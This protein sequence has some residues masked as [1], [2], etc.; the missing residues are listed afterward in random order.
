MKS[1]VLF[2]LF[3]Y[4]FFLY[5]DLDEDNKLKMGWIRIEKGLK[6]RYF[7][8]TRAIHHRPVLVQTLMGSL[9]VHDLPKQRVQRRLCNFLTTSLTH[10]H[11]FPNRFEKKHHKNPKCDCLKADKK[12]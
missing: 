3:I 2:Y 10:T 7:G 6:F 11:F 12:S 5:I 8:R 4:L 9:Q 1:H